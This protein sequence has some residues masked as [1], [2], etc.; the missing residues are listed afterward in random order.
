MKITCGRIELS[1]VQDF[2]D[3]LLLFSRAWVHFEVSTNKELASHDNF[4][5]EFKEMRAGYQRQRLQILTGTNNESEPKQGSSKRRVPKV[6]AGL[7]AASK[8][9]CVGLADDI[10]ITHPFSVPPRRGAKV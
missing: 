1:D 6:F 8:K 10:H 4:R 7:C 5:L 9:L 2:D 3:S